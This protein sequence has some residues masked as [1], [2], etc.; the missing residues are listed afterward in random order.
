[1]SAATAVSAGR[2]HGGLGGGTRCT[3]SIR[4]SLATAVC[5]V[6]ALV[7][8]SGA[9]RG[10]VIHEYRSQ[11][12]GVPAGA[13]VYSPG[14]VT[15]LGAMTV[16]SGHLWAA[17]HV[18]GTST[19][20][21]DRFNASN[22]AFERQL[23]P[24]GVV[25]Y[26][27]GSGI[28][29]G[30]ATGEG[31]VYAGGSEQS[32]GH[33][34]SVVYAFSE[35]GVLLDTWTGTPAG[36]FKSVRSVAVDSSAALGDW[37]AGDVYVA[38]TS[39]KAVDVFKPKAGGGEEYVTQITGV[40]ASTP[41]TEPSRV[42]LD[43]SSGDVLVV[44]RT[45]GGWQVDVFA[46]ATLP[47]KYEFL[48]R[49]TGPP[50]SERFAADSTGID[51]VAAAGEV[52]YVGEGGA[53]SAGGA[54]KAV[55]EFSVADGAFLGRVTGAATPAGA[56]AEPRSVA[57]NPAAP[58]GLYVGDR[59]EELS[60]GGVIDLFGPALV[61]PDVTTGATSGAAP[62]GREGGLRVTLHGTVNPDGA[63]A[64]SCRFAWGAT[65]ALA[66]STNCSATVP[67]GESAVP[68]QAT[69]K[70]LAPDT[71]YTYRLQASNAAGTNP[72]E[73]W[74]DRQLTTPGPGLHG[75]WATTVDATAADLHAAIDAHGA[76]TWVYFQYGTSTAYG[77][78]VPAATEAAPY[79][80]A[81]GSGEGD[82][83]VQQRAQALA[84]QT[85]YH[86]RVV[87]VSELAPGRFTSFHG[88]DQTFTTATSAP[89]PP[90][91]DGRRWQL[92][93]PP[94]L[95]G[96]ALVGIKKTGGAIQAAAGG[97]AITYIA[98]GAADPGAEGEPTGQFVQLLSQ[99][100]AG[101]TWVTQDIASRHEAMSGGDTSAVI[102]S[103][104]PLFSENLA[105]ALAEP[106]GVTLLSPLATERTPYLRRQQVCEAQGSS[107]P[108]CFLP[109][110]TAREG[111]ADVTSGAAF[112]GGRSLYGYLYGDVSVAGASSNLEH[113]V[114]SSTVPL[115]KGETAPASGSLLY[116]WSE[117]SAP[118]DTLQPI[119]V[120]PDGKP[121]AC[122]SLGEG[123]SSVRGSGGDVRGAVSQDGSR[124]IWS[125]GASCSEHHLYMR[126][127][128]TGQTIQLD[129]G[130]SHEGGHAEFQAA[131]RQGTRVFFRDTEALT[132]DSGAGGT[133]PDLYVC[134]IVEAAGRYECRLTDLTPVAGGEHAEVQRNVLGIA[135][136]GSYAYFVA[137]GALAPGAVKG[138]CRGTAESAQRCNLYV[139]HHTGSSW[140]APHLV[141]VLSGADARDWEPS[142]NSPTMSASVSPDGRWLT[143]M[144]SQPLTG[145]DNRGA[146]SGQPEEEVYL[147]DAQTGRLVCASCDPTGARPHGVLRGAIG[148]GRAEA[149]RLAESAL[150]DGAELW[151]G[152]WLAAA[153]PE[154]EQLSLGRAQYQPRYMFDNGRL[155]FN[156]A[157]GL[158]PQAR[159]HTW[160]VYEYEPPGVGSC[161]EA[162]ST[163]SARSGGCV[164]LISSGQSTSESAFL[165]AGETGNDAFFLTASKLTAEDRGGEYAVYDAH[166]CTAA[167]PCTAAATAAPTQ[168]DTAAACKGGAAAAGGGAGAPATLT[169]S[170]N[171][172]LTRPPVK[173][174]GKK[175]ARKARHGKRRTASSRKLRSAMAKCRRR[176][177]SRHARKRGIC[178]R[179]AR[180]RFGAHLSGR[181]RLRLRP[182]RGRARRGARRHARRRVGR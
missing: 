174:T 126:E 20:R 128:A 2:N 125:G 7:L 85:E 148:A 75:E 118:A 26:S 21:V 77:S 131:S 64:A 35:A 160:D 28:A 52:L 150:V 93:S 158:V 40:S 24:S 89:P 111:H 144:S 166:V 180:Q 123:G 1:M 156:A 54:E 164:S 102:D 22:G 100:G 98:R 122:A 82:A 139:V 76:P 88:P 67:N 140:E 149:E 101:G 66:S 8:L 18:E 27:V 173:I 72:G 59:R 38:D 44:D 10:A 179:R 121:A 61:V 142:F 103:E 14:P 48:R 138:T 162:S 68:V 176:R 15:E 141:A 62:E 151:R 124:V 73:A 165:D 104:Y 56:F 43:P 83:A 175:G 86:Y 113:V 106:A 5:V 105:A 154:W 127:L 95:H 13:G 115:L 153:L 4:A 129:S 50:P 30:H 169:P 116:E 60:K 132:A 110:A 170:G 146:V 133:A 119:G 79:G 70:G 94:D 97:E 109:L 49:I 65:S 55:S 74:Q 84:P 36:P 45:A 171:G 3:R 80:S 16:D 71:E 11:V 134:E 69:V 29:V 46:P 25:G 17:E 130:I 167:A 9:A 78:D 90:L 33:F 159:N 37:A 23:Q 32:S 42:A 96:A 182:R 39:A 63:G 31:V 81:I 47:G 163:Y 51:A 114:I 53:Q 58:Y 152:R 147:Y 12:T 92:V 178:E 91:P 136:D 108:E 99:R 137:D 168:C 41:F 157:A 107:G 6:L 34:E 57:V 117:G 143:F 120:L 172:N 19:Y 181:G 112:G 177:D 87:A 161:T 155:F 145:Y 135:A